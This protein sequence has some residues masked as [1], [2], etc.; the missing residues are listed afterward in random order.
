[1]NWKGSFHSL[2]LYLR[3]GKA[4]PFT[5]S[6]DD[7]LEQWIP[8]VLA[9]QGRAN[10]CPGRIVVPVEDESMY[11]QSVW[12]MPNIPKNA[13][14]SEELLAKKCARYKDINAEATNMWDFHL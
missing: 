4:P 8:A 1:M 3:F 12:R 11:H 5:R 14:H 6:E 2:A 10:L 7:K 9:T 13:K